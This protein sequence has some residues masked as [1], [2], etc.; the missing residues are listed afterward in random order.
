MSSPAA[1]PVRVEKRGHIM[2]VTLDRPKVNAI[3]LATSRALGAA[4]QELQDDPNL[5]VGIVTAAGTVASPRAQ[6]VGS[7]KAG[8]VTGAGVSAGTSAGGANGGKALGH[9]K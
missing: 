1:N 8:A 9:T 4:F 7:G 6:G 2:E 5:R 3:D